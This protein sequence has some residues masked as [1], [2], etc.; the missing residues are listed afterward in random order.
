MSLRQDGLWRV[1]EDELGDLTPVRARDLIIECFFRAQ[2]HAR[3]FSSPLQ[4]EVH[5]RELRETM[6]V[7]LRFRFEDLGLDFDNPSPDC[8]GIIASELARDAELWGTPAHVVE[9][10][11]GELRRIE[12][13][14]TDE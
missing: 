7:A 13:C 12:A 5:D 3:R 8:I 14:L 9:H 1:S 10:H 2:H 6:R 11:I 4:T